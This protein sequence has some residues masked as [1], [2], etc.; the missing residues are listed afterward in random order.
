MAHI[1]HPLESKLKQTRTLTLHPGEFNDIIRLTLTTISLSDPPPYEALSYVWGKDQA[2]IPALVEDLKMPI[3]QN[4][5]IAFR[6]LR[7]PDTSRV[8]W[9]DAI[10]INQNDMSERENQVK[11][12]GEIYR[13]ST[14]TLIWLGAA[15]NDSD[16]AMRSIAGEKFDKEYWQTYDFQV[17]FMDILFRPWFTRIW[18]VQEFVLGKNHPRIGCGHIWVYWLGFIAAWG[19]FEENMKVIAKR[20]Q[21]EYVATVNETFSSSWIQQAQKITQS[22][23]VSENYIFGCLRAC[24]GEDFL[25][26]IRYTTISQLQEDI[27][28]NRSSWLARYAVMRRCQYET[29]AAKTY[30]RRLELLRVVPLTYHHFLTHARGTLVLQKRPLTFA[31]ILKGT[32]NLRSTDPRDKIYGMLGLVSDQARELIPVRYSQEPEWTFVPTMAYIIQHE[33]DGIALLGL[34]WDRRSFNIPFPSWVADF[35]ISADPNNEHSP[36]F[37]RGSCVNATWNW[38]NEK[39]VSEN[40]TTFSAAG[41]SFGRVI[42]VVPFIE[43]DGR[44]FVS[45]LSDIEK[46]AKKYCTGENEPLW[47]TL[48][49]VRNTSPELLREGMPFNQR[50]EL[51]M[52]VR[53]GEGE[54]GGGAFAAGV[55]QLRE[56]MEEITRGRSFFVTDAGFVGVSTP[57]I[58]KGDVVAIVFG[59]V[60]AAVLRSVEPRDLG[61]RVKVQ[62][63]GADVD[64][65]KIAGFAQV[66]T[67]SAGTRYLRSSLGEPSYTTTYIAI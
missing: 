53:G 9:V 41:M 66:L 2:S 14:T 37:L 42:E 63:G 60:R 44:A 24:Y 19:H 50:F 4:L 33:P 28:N 15:A 47:R 59:M 25:E 8:L 26:H 22:E 51:L 64:F 11:V 46:L 34:L 40:L 18:V 12:M 1:Y 58:Q 36:V 5:D 10:C 38:P 65:H 39:S 27:S 45:Q 6:H 23:N 7:H 16:L 67:S 3:T 20:Y 29:D 13:F 31:T 52:G 32:M 49:G 54:A 48:I 55:D 30:W 62:D 56:Y 61:V 43:G 17:Q 57:G 35:T 21:N